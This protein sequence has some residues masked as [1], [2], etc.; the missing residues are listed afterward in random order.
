[1]TDSVFQSRG[2]DRHNFHVDDNESLTHVRPRAS[3]PSASDTSL[4]WQGELL[5]IFLRNQMNLAPIMPIITLLLAMTALLWV[6]PSVVMAWLVGTLGC[7]TVQL[8]LCN[9]YFLQTRNRAEQHDWIGMISASEFFQGVFWIL[10]LFYFWPD[11][12]PL[13]RT[14]LIAAVMA[15]SVVRLLVVANFMPV[16]IAGTGMMALGVALR[17]VVEADI[18]YFSLASLIIMLEVF[19]LFV[20]RQL[21][22]TA[23]DRLIFRA[24]KDSLIEELKQEK[25]R[26]ERERHAAEDANRAKSA[27]LA[28]MSHELR[29]PLNAILGFSEVLEQELFGPL[30]NKSYKD[31]AGDI[32]TSG[33]YLLTLINDILDLSRIEA[34][35]RDVMEEPVTMKD[36]MDHARSMLANRIASKSIT[37]T[38]DAAASLPKLLCDYRAVNQIA[39]NLLTNAVKFT[40]ENG[41]VTMSARVQ[42]DGRMAFIVSD[43][44]P[45]IPKAEQQQLLQAFSRGAHA[46]KQ[47]I[48]GAGLGLPIVKGLMDI[49]DGQL[50]I[51]SESGKG[52]DIICYFPMKRVLSGPRGEAIASPAVRTDSQRRLI[53]MTG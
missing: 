51:D 14:F 26:A 35:R 8:Y 16:L 45:G 20:A 2:L 23:R 46:T 29:T 44:G 10:P 40:P 17:C 48:D 6:T 9:R 38:V 19:F 27:F 24:E 11:A 32:N 41:K 42:L 12:T 25:N 18:I 15:V 50:V 39:I 21:Q 28:N 4:S 34:G 36:C 33:R 1:M 13:H 31:Y 49:H 3:I 7:H 5:E 30:Q 47:A 53:T 43:N 52:T 37:I 22:E